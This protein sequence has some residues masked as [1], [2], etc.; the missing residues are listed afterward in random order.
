MECWD[1]PALG[2]RAA[3]GLVAANDF[4]TRY[5]YQRTKSRGIA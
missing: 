3:E 1:Q 4:R 5:L 2:Q